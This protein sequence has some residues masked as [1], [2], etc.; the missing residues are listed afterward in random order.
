METQI[1]IYNNQ[2]YDFEPTLITYN[3]D[4]ELVGEVV[5]SQREFEKVTSWIESMGKEYVSGPLSKAIALTNI[6]T[7]GELAEKLG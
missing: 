3:L 6:A 5:Y 2:R 7:V 4:R 1:K